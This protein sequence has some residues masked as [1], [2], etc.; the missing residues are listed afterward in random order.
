MV[1]VILSLLT[2]FLLR[3][4]ITLMVLERR[5]QPILD[6]IGLSATFE[7]ARLLSLTELEVA[8]VKLVAQDEPVVAVDRVRI[9]G[10][11]G[12]TFCC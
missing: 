11:K 6:R 2:V 7:S 8:G 1:L 5:S 4:P 9:K 12:F 10:T 3:D